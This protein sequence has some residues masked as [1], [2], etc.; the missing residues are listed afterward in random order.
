MTHPR[1]VTHW[2]SGLPRAAGLGTQDPLQLPP[3]SLLLSDPGPLGVQAAGLGGAQ[4]FWRAEQSSS[5]T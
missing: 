4:G 3:Q 1:T 2:S 5:P